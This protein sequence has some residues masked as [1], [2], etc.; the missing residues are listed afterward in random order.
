MT[1]SRARSATRTFFAFDVG[2]EKKLYYAFSSFRPSLSTQP[3]EARLLQHPRPRHPPLRAR[4]SI[5]RSRVLESPSPQK[6]VFL[7]ADA[8]HREQLASAAPRRRRSRHLRRQT[9][10]RARGVLSVE[11]RRALPARC[12]GGSAAGACPAAART[13][14][15]PLARAPRRRAWRCRG[16]RAAARTARPVRRAGAPEAAPCGRSRAGSAPA[17]CRTARSTRS[18]AR[19]ACHPRRARRQ[20]RDPDTRTRRN[21]RARLCRTHRVPAR[22]RCFLARRRFLDPPCLCCGG[23]PGVSRGGANRSPRTRTS[24]P[25]ASRRPRATAAASRVWRRPIQVRPGR[26]ARTTVF[27]AARRLDVLVLRSRFVL[28]LNL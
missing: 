13:T 1:V 5:A 3:T 20:S 2:L 19:S 18:T 8:R 10:A 12:A 14:A 24:R 6:Y 21:R 7:R 26:A 27:A 25:R 22:R 23:I 11:H 9:R 4:P 16:S 15:A 17:C 28:Q